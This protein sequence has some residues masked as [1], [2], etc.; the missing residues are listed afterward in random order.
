LL[1]WL[2]SLVSTHVVSDA[3]IGLSY[4]AI[5]G[6]LV[7]LVWR[8]RRELPYSWMFVAFG[9]FIVACGATHFMEIWTLWMPVFWLSAGVKIIVL[10]SSDA[11]RDI[12]LSYAL[13]ANCCVTKPGELVAFQAMV[14]AVGDFWCRVAKL[15]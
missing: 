14:K 3:L 8:A 1:P 13:G 12:V 4:V 2:P 9:T 5:S 7:F 15:P 10:T 11:G 6:T